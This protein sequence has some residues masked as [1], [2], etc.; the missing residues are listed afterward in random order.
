MRKTGSKAKP[1]RGKK[2][3][4]EYLE[5]AAFHYLGR[6][7][8]SSGNLARI[9]ERKVKRRLEPGAEAP[10]GAGEWITGVVAKCVRLGLVDDRAFGAAKIRS[11]T[12]AGRS[13]RQIYGY[14]RSKFLDG[15]L[16]TGLIEE[17]YA[18]EGLSEMAAALKYAKRRRFGPFSRSVADAPP[19]RPDAVAP[20]DREEAEKAR[21][22]V[23]SAFS[24]AGFPYAMARK[25]LAAKTVKEAEAL[26]G[27]EVV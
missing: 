24:R 16:I 13:R 14:L 25:I 1:R 5:R 2:I 23:M 20:V 21:R 22:R 27:E 11:M 18:E 6:Y 15:E 9:L 4:P 3:T 26:A 12:R 7:A 17:A 8:S 10:D 19:A